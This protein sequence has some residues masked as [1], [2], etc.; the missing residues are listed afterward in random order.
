MTPYLDIFIKD[1]LEKV[2]PDQLSITSTLLFEMFPSA[3]QAKSSEN[4]PTST[5]VRAPWCNCR[6]T[7]RVQMSNQ[8]QEDITGR[9]AS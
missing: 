1:A 7:P 3:A 2:L 4:V 9:F 6:V 5:T 8:S